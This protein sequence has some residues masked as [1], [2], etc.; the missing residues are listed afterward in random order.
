MSEEFYAISVLTVGCTGN[1]LYCMEIVDDR[2][3]SCLI[4]ETTR[5][6]YLK[7][8]IWSLCYTLRDGFTLR[9]P[10][11]C[12]VALRWGF[13]SSRTFNH[14]LL[15]RYVLSK[16]GDPLTYRHIAISRKTG[17]LHYKVAKFSELTNPNWVWSVRYFYMKH[18]LTT[19]FPRSWRIRW[20]NWWHFTHFSKFFFE[21][22]WCILVCVKGLK[23]RKCMDTYKYVN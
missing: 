6:I 10:V 2:P 1:A 9:I 21:V 18:N 22:I 14:C 16:H 19:R 15:S 17:I 13:I 20:N 3:S 12:G 23:W 8:G 11:L 7:F 4:S 5:W